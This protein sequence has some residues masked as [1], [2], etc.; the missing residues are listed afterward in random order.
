VIS[1]VMPARNNAPY[2]REAIDSILGQTEGDLELLV[3]DDASSDDTAAVVSSVGDP[4]VRLLRNEIRLG[5]AG[6][7]NR[8][9]AAARGEY[10]ARMDADDVAMPTRL[11]TQRAFL[12]AHPRVA[13]CGT[14]VRMF[15][16][17]WHRDRRLETHPERMRC[18]L[19]LF[20]VLSHP[21]A[22]WRRGA[23]AQ[24]GL[25]YDESFTNSE[26]YDLWCRASHVVGIAN[27]PAVL[28]RYRVHGAQAGHDRPA[29]LREGERVRLAQ[30]ARL[31]ASLT[32]EQ[33][34]VH[35]TLGIAGRLPSAAD[36]RGWRDALLAANGRTRVYDAGVL[37]AVLNEQ[38]FLAGAWRHATPRT[39]V[40]LAI[41]AID[42]RRR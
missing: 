19:L 15:D 17:A 38:L 13:L 37:C 32:P 36:G 3:I 40:R 7:V 11:A 6:S 23:F 31:G 9:I 21:T 5:I 22:M 41:G 2:V 25:T 16:G 27:V 30:L 26:D 20:N 29:R 4:R 34:A 42:D 28:L 12:E 10:I 1:V 35:H 24:H 8:G 33:L 39:L 14:W 18:A